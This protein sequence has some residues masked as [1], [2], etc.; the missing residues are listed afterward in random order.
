[1]T[2]GTWLGMIIYGFFWLLLLLYLMVL[3]N[4]DLNEDDYDAYDYKNDVPMVDGPSSYLFDGDKSKIGLRQS[5]DEPVQAS[6][7][8]PSSAYQEEEETNS[9]KVLRA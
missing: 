9:N 2:N 3:K 5:A 1:M 4:S 8:Q 7:I 6:S